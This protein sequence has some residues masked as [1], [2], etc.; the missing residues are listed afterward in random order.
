PRAAG[1]AEFRVVGEL[2][3]V[4]YAQQHLVGSEH[5]RFAFDLDDAGVSG[6]RVLLERGLFEHAKVGRADQDLSYSPIAW[7]CGEMIGER[8]CKRRRHAHHQPGFAA[9]D[10]AK[11]DAKERPGREV[12][13]APPLLRFDGLRLRPRGR[14]WIDDVQGLRFGAPAFCVRAARLLRFGFRLRRARLHEVAR[15]RDARGK[16]FGVLKHASSLTTGDLQLAVRA[17]A[18]T[19]A[20]NRLGDTDTGNRP[21][22]KGLRALTRKRKWTDVLALTRNRVFD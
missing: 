9:Q 12:R 16:T 6:L 10:K 2:L 13:S 5:A 11:V 17:V 22:L 1:P 7:G 4:D 3:G 8:E 19:G 18:A 15:Q 21:W 14:L 20:R